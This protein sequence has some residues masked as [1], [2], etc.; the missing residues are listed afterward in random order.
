MVEAVIAISNKPIKMLALNKLR[1]K[2]YGAY[3]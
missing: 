3:S 2:N 1:R